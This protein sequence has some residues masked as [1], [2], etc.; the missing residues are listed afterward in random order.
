MEGLVAWARVFR[1]AQVLEVT[2]A[3]G[4]A[5]GDFGGKALA[6]AGHCLIHYTFQHKEPSEFQVAAL[7][8]F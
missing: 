1:A 3:C 2:T 8:G 7:R 5:P 4:E 6:Y